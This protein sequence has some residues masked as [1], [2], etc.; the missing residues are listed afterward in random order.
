MADTTDLDDV[1]D[2]EVQH[3]LMWKYYKRAKRWEQALASSRRCLTNVAVAAA[4]LFGLVTGGKA[5]W[6]VLVALLGR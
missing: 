4:C 5:A 6:D 1:T 3:N 2:R